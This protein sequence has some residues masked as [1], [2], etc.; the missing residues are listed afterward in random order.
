VVVELETAV[1]PTTAAVEPHDVVAYA[2][3]VEL[4]WVVVVEGPDAAMPWVA[5][6]LVAVLELAFV[7]VD[8]VVVF[9][10]LIVVAYSLALGDLG[11][12]VESHAEHM[13]PLPVLGPVFLVYS[14]THFLVLSFLV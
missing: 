5:V 12:A 6:E 9:A 14:I 1:V 7:A 11:V 3:T 4:G 2:A 8:S 13:Q 10:M